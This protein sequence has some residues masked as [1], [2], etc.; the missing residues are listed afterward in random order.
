MCNASVTLGPAGRCRQHMRPSRGA[1]AHEGGEVCV[2]C[3][4]ADP[5]GDGRGGRATYM[6]AGLFMRPRGPMRPSGAAQDCKTHYHP[7]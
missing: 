4:C 3:D 6:S 2:M 1:A 5:S 7:L